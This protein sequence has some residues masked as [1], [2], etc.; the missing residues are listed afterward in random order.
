MVVCHVCSINNNVLLYYS[1]DVPD[2]EHVLRYAMSASPY[3]QSGDYTSEEEKDGVLSL[4]SPSIMQHHPR[5]SPSIVECRVYPTIKSEIWTAA[6]TSP[7]PRHIL[8]LHS[9]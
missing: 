1:V 4:P 5:K 8:E 7:K 6:V 2:R 3:S 9:P